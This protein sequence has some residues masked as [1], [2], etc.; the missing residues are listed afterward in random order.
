MEGK[1]IQGDL[2]KD[3]PFRIDQL[4]VS[5]NDLPWSFIAPDCQAL[6]STPPSIKFFILAFAIN[7]AV[8]TAAKHRAI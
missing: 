7:R 3:S 8:D 6:L 1:L 4:L 2:S 5:P